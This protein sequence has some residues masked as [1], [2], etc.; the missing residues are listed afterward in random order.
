MK[1]SL[2]LLSCCLLLHFSAQ[3]QKKETKP[4]QSASAMLNDATTKTRYMKEAVQ[5]IARPNQDFIKD[6]LAIEDKLRSIQKKMNGDRVAERLD[7]DTPPGISSRLLSA[8]FDGY[9]TTS[10]P[11]STMKEQLQIASEEFEGVLSE[12]KTV[13]N[14]DIKTLEQKLEVA[15]APYTPGR[16]PEYKKN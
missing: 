8:I 11:T 14:T 15:G 12:L 5:S 2:L 6:V 7:I 4:V 9:G 16:L 1:K 3:S 10:D 13:V